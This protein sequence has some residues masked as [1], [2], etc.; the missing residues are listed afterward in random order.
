MGYRVAVVGATG[1]VGREM[2]QILSDRNFPADE[3]IALA[4]RRS[5]GSKVSFGDERELRIHDLAS[6]NFQGI[7]IALFSPG[8]KISA[9]FAPKA[10]HAGAVV[11]DNTSH[12]RMDRDVPLIV[13][14]VNPEALIGYKAR[15]I[16]AN[17]NCSTI[18]LVTVLKPLHDLV[19]IRRVVVATYQAVSGG[20]QACMDELFNQTRS[21]FVNDPSKPEYFTKQIAFNLIPHIDSFMEDGTTREEWKM[22]VET[23]KILDPAIR[24]TATCVRTPVFVGHAEAVNIE[25]EDVIDEEQI[26]AAL[27]AA[28]GVVLFDR[29]QDEG[30][31]TPRECAGE[32]AVYVS[33]LRIDSTIDCGL[34]L[35]IVADNL[36]KGAALN[37]V[38]IAER[39]V[40][41]HLGASK[42]E[43]SEKAKKLPIMALS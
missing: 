10:A 17:P 38:Q 36:R 8:A 4:S 34:N 41:D 40:S 30:Y 1:S 39:L 23:K 11:I 27:D 22:M 42:T 43:Q 3:V 5:I 20:G 26:R 25:F 32:D 7:D 6:Y 21:I 33:R 28:P 18:Q 2:L 35:W 16:I 37:S 13:P 15:N 19:P 14:E 29:R 9:E 12:F 24:L 31:V